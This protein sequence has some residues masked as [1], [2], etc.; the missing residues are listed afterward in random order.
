MYVLGMKKLLG[1]KKNSIDKAYL[2]VGIVQPKMFFWGEFECIMFHRRISFRFT[3]TSR[4]KF[5]LCNVYTLM[6]Q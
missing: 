1:V 2:V 3:E 4:K 5:D 6:I